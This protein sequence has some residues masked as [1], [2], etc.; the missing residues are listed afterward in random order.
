[1]NASSKD[2][3]T[4]SVVFERSNV[5]PS[6]HPILRDEEALSTHYSFISNPKMNA[7]IKANECSTATYLVTF[8]TDHE[9]IDSE[10]N[11]FLL[12]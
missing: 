7:C 8:L 2:P 6:I 12:N 4:V 10:L 11:L 1:M 3:N 5:S 9:I